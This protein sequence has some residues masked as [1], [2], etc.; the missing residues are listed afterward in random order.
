MGQ[1]SIYQIQRVS[2]SQFWRGLLEIREWYGRGRIVKVKSGL[3]TRFWEDPWIG[4]CPL[5]I[6]FDKLFQICSEP[7]ASVADIQRGGFWVISFRRS[8]YPEELEKWH[9][10]QTILEEVH[11]VEGRDEIT[12]ALENLLQDPCTGN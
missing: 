3:Q 7:N 10:L 6:E 5:K 4:E 11:L 2:G 9:E 8:L 12:W 1:K